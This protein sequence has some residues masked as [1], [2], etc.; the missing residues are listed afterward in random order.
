M[1]ISQEESI[2]LEGT[3]QEGHMTT[4]ND[5][6]SMRLG[7][8][9][10]EIER[11]FDLE[12]DPRAIRSEYCGL[13]RPPPPEHLTTHCFACSHQGGKIEAASQIH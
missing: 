5:S 1:K 4:Q 9:V 6:V 11:P 12:D 10:D 2:K 3:S 13:E 8:Y 7:R